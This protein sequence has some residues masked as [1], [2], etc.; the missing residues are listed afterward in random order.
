[1]DALATISPQRPQMQALLVGEEPMRAFLAERLP[2]TPDWLRTS[3][4]VQDA[5]WLFAAA[6]IFVSASRHEGQSGAIGEALACRLPVVMSD[7]PGT[8]AWEEAPHISTFPSE[9]SGALA[10]EIQALLAETPQARGAAGAENLRWVAE[11][12]S[13]ERWCD[14]MAAIYGSLLPEAAAGAAALR[15]GGDARGYAA[16]PARRRG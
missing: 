8:A 7:I 14:E 9:D 5:A 4:F 15:P 6:D 1:V 3:G 10:T 11:N 13:T 16:P 12:L 2:S